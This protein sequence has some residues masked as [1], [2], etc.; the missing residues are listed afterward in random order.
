MEA[1]VGLA[2]S[3][4]VWFSVH[5]TAQAD[6][7]AKGEVWND[8]HPVLDPCPSSRASRYCPSSSRRADRSLLRFAAAMRD[9][10][11]YTSYVNKPGLVHHTDRDCDDVE[12]AGA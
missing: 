6:M 7:A 8:R 9:G 3:E 4:D 10:L 11:R 2:V 12:H 5:C 1:P